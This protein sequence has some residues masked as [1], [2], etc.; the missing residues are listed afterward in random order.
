[1]AAAQ[2]EIPV[3]LIL[4]NISFTLD[5]PG[6]EMTEPEFLTR[7]VEETGCGLLLDVTN[8]YI[9]SRNHR[10]DPRRFL[11]ALPLESIVQLHF[12]GE[13]ELG[14]EVIDSHARPTSPAIWKLLED[15]LRIAP[16]KGAILE[17]DDRLPPFEDLLPEIV[18]ARTLG[19]AHRRWD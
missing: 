11:E 4:E 14:G 19:R 12:V 1:V 6:S 15:V 5:W 7:L 13:E 17:R 2:R 18:Q 16:V 9:N 8:L 10:Y 3:P